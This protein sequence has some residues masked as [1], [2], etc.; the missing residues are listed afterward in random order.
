[1]LEVIAFA[2][3]QARADGIFDGLHLL[4]HGGELLLVGFYL[5]ALLA[6][7]DRG[8]DWPEG[9]FGNRFGAAVSIALNAVEIGEQAVV[10]L[11]RE[12]IDLVIVAARTVDCEPK[13]NLARGGE[14]IIQLIVERLDR[15]NGLIVP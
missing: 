9:S 12:G 11:L 10:V 4:P 7:L 3:F 5:R 13:K 14:D 1:M 8:S 6:L 15:V 2:A